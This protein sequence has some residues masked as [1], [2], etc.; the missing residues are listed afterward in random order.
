MIIFPPLTIHVDDQEHTTMSFL[1]TL[2][3]EDHDLFRQF[4]CGLLQRNADFQIVGQASDGVEA[5]EKT[6]ELQPDLILLDIGLPQLNGIEAARRMRKLAPHSKILFVSQESSHDVVREGLSLGAHGYIL[7]PHTHSDLFPAINALREGKRF[8]SAALKFR[9]ETDLHA[10]G[11]HKILFYADDSAL[12]D[13]CARFITSALD[14]KNPAG[15]WMIET[16]LD[17]LLRKLESEGI[18]IHGAIQRGI[19]FSSSEMPDLPRLLDVIRQLSEAAVKGGKKN[20]RVAFCGG[21]STRLWTAGKRDQAI[22]LEQQSSELIKRYDIDLVC[23]YPLDHGT[24]D[25]EFESIRAE[26]SAIYS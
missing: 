21:I 26:H 25:E 3:V 18:D 11:S 1:R 16:H 22:R 2:V 24:T 7:K 20:P 14:A 17:S 15:V 6:S 8:V 5:V 9:E 10:C 13:G 4:I 23:T 12:V 19:Y